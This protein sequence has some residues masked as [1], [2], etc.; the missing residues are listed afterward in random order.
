MTNTRFEP[1]IGLEVHAQL[2]TRSKMFCGCDAHYFQA[3]P[4]SHVCAVCCGMPGALPVINRRAVDMVVLTSL[5]LSCAVAP[6]SK[7]DRKNYPYPDLP[8]GYQISQYDLPIGQSGHLEYLVGVAPRRCGIVRVHLEEDTGKSLHSDENDDRSFLDYNR[9]GVPLMEIVGEPELRSAE[10]ARAYFETLRQV[11]MY[12]DVCDGNLQEGSMRA[13]VNVSLHEHGA[14]YGTQVEIKNLNSFRAVFRALEHEIE[15]QADLLR[16]GE[17]V[18]RETR[19]WSEK[20]EV[21]VSQRSKEQA[22]DYRYFPEPDLPPIVLTGAYLSAMSGRLPELPAKKLERFRQQYGLAE[23][24]A[25]VLIQERVLADFFENTVQATS[26]VEPNV[27]ANW[28][29]GDVLRLAKEIDSSITNM[30]LTPP[31]L[32]E[33]LGLLQS[34]AIN[35]TS[36][37]V[38]LETIVRSGEAP[39]DIVTRLKL[40]RIA[41]P[42]LLAPVVRQVL[43]ENQRLVETYLSGKTN[44]L[45]AIRGK[46]MKATDGKA[47]M[48]AVDEILAE[49]LE[50]RTRQI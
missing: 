42:A 23:R 21:T 20:R 18:V 2:N 8:K 9:C 5:A 45:Q 44:A 41:D 29:I 19:G 22:H 32:G 12:L 25:G 30:K 17:S 10:E 3:T 43:Q 16:R 13:D 37:K 28:I 31:L 48:K 11:L 47:D 24:V 46:V 39:S 6:Q 26:R 27:I 14:P 36:A 34:G 15:R 49:D 1:V 40:G 33:L 7:F 38:V 4:N 50:V 35:G